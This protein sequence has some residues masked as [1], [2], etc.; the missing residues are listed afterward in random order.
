[1]DET[2]DYSK[3]NR[4]LVTIEKEFEFAASKFGMFHSTHEGYA[5]LKE[6]VDECW[7]RIKQNSNLCFEEAVQVA[8]MAIRFIYDLADDQ[9]LD[10]IHS[11]INDQLWN[12]RMKKKMEK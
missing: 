3:L 6:E 8:A 1:M 2:N 5:I 9:V 7:D 4:I 10:R 11:S 12:E